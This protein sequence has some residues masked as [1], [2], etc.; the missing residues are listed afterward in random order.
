MVSAMKSPCIVFPLTTIYCALED[1][2]KT[3]KSSAMA[4][5]GDYWVYKIVTT[6]EGLEKEKNV[7]YLLD[8]D[9]EVQTVRARTKELDAHLRKVNLTCTEAIIC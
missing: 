9:E 2:T 1:G 6:I 7:S 3:L 5:D 8:P 4:T